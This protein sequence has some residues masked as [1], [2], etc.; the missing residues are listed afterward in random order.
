[1]R[2]REIKEKIHH[3]RNVDSWGKTHEGALR[4]IKIAL[5]CL[6]ADIGKSVAF[7]KC[8]VGCIINIGIPSHRKDKWS[9][10][11]CECLTPF[12]GIDAKDRATNQVLTS[13]RKRSG[14]IF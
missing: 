7:S 6:H 11:P 1:M 3:F 10:G 4:K 8:I 2:S 14:P 12:A 5:I 13:G 9:V